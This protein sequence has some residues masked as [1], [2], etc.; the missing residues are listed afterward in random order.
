MD[1]IGCMQREL[2]FAAMANARD[3]GGL[4][5]ADGSQ[6]RWKSLVRAD[7]AARLTPQGVRAVVE[8]GVRTVI[9]LRFPVELRN[10]PSPFAARMQSPAYV[11]CSLL[12]ES[13]QSWIERGAI[14]NDSY[15]Y[16]S[17]LDC[18]QNEMRHVLGI[19]ADAPEGGVLFHCTAGKDRTGVVA[20]LL[21]ALA[22]V[23]DESIIN[24]YALTAPNLM[25]HKD[26]ELAGVSDPAVRARIEDGYRCEPQFAAHT[27]AHLR[28]RYGGA[29]GYLRTI[30]LD[31]Q[32]ITRLRVRLA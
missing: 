8:Y 14:P 11:C 20:M 17:F 21:L 10:D 5:T 29:E 31:A 4:R 32:Q 28:R 25:L 7:S 1:R 6:T 13:W 2:Y 15:W 27:L 22:G 19:I 12:G 26:M 18:S 23:P 24:D 3:L 9:D 16:S 30:G